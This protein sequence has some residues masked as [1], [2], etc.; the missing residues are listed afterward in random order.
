MAETKDE[1]L[2][3]DTGDEVAEIAQANEPMK[4]KKGKKPK[5]KNKPKQ[6]K[7]QRKPYAAHKRDEEPPSASQETLDSSALLNQ[8]LT[9]PLENV[10]PGTASVS[11]SPRVTNSAVVP[12][13]DCLSS[14]AEIKKS[15]KQK[16]SPSPQQQKLENTSHIIRRHVERTMATV[17]STSEGSGLGKSPCAEDRV[18]EDSAIGRQAMEN[19]RIHQEADEDLVAGLSAPLQ[20]VHLTGDLTNTQTSTTSAVSSTV[21]KFKFDSMDPRLLCPKPDCRRMTS[22]WDSLVVICPAC[23]PE[24]YVRYCRKEHLFEDIQRHWVMECEKARILGPIDRDTIRKS[25]TP[26]RAYVV[27]HRHNLVERHR[28]AVYR[29]MSESDYFIFN[30]VEMVDR[31]IARPSNEEWN[32]VRGTG[33]VV[34]QLVFPD[35]MTP[36]SSRRLFEHHIVQCLMYG[37]PLARESCLTAFHLIREALIISGN[38]TEQIVTYLCM[39]LAGEWGGFAVPEHFRNVLEVNKMWRE[40]GL[41]PIL[42]SE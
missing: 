35:D 23:G 25:Q 9:R 15:H 36:Q 19:K 10:T 41:L 29:A 17:G 3:E 4:S 1:K 24:S 33:Q 20:N 42:Q 32:A 6:R 27:G 40:R 5:K 14:P 2:G 13:V 28:Q 26:T 38:W 31:D 12:D 37:N 7:I 34:L 8:G 16:V 11:Q 39:Q 21:P 22:C 18:K 30:D